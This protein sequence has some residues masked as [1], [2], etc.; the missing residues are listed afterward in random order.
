MVVEAE[1]RLSSDNIKDLYDNR[2]NP[3]ATISGQVVAWGQ[4]TL[5]ALP[6]ALDRISIR[7]LLLNLKKYVSS[8][9]QY[10]VFEKN[11]DVTREKFINKVT[12]YMNDVRSKQG[13]YTFE[14]KMD[15]ENNTAE[16]IDRNELYGQIWIEPAKD[17]ETII[18]DFNITPTGGTFAQ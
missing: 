5:Q 15:N 8:I 18:I 3:L 1:F 11:T 10:L 7:R 2:I 17:A 6:S 12:P 14:I 13:L 9:S 4:K 16:V